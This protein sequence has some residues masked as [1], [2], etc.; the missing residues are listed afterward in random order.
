MSKLDNLQDALTKLSEAGAGLGLSEQLDDFGA[1]LYEDLVSGIEQW[2]ERCKSEWAE[3]AP[4]QT[5]NLRNSIDYD[6]DLEE[7]KVWVGVDVDRLLSVAGQTLPF[8][9]RKYY[10]GEEVKDSQVMPDYDYTYEAN[11]VAVSAG[12]QNPAPGDGALTPFIE[13]IW[14]VIAQNEKERIFG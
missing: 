7:L 6:T 10:Y 5:E 2:G 4:W 12:K 8:K 3:Q 1:N 14:H 9:R 13:E 11:E